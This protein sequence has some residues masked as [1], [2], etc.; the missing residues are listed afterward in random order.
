MR[1]GASRRSELPITKTNSVNFWISTARELW[2]LD[3][4]SLHGQMGTCMSTNFIQDISKSDAT[5]Q[6]EELKSI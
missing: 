6:T 5:T 2:Y 1:P 3:I 4:E